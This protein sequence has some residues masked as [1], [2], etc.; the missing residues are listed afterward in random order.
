MNEKTFAFYIGGIKP[1]N[2]DDVSGVIRDVRIITE[3]SALGHNV[4]IDSTTIDQIFAAC[5]QYANGVKVKMNH[6]GGAG[7][8]PGYVTN[9]RKMSD[10]T[11]EYLLGDLHLFAAH[12]QRAYILEMA[13]RIPD[14]FGLSL[15][16]I[17]KPE[18]IEG[19]MKARC[20]RV[21]S[22]DIVTEPAANPSLF[23]VGPIVRGTETSQVDKIKKSMTPEEF[24]QC[25][26]TYEAGKAGGA[27]GAKVVPTKETHEVKEDGS[28]KHVITKGPTAPAAEDGEGEKDEESEMASR[29]A[30]KVMSQLAAQGIRLKANVVSDSAP[31]TETQKEDA[32]PMTFERLVNHLVTVGDETGKKFSRS[33]AIAFAAKRHSDLHENYLE[34]SAMDF[35]LHRKLI[36]AN[37]AGKEIAVKFNAEHW[38]VQGTAKPQGN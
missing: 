27:E 17:G 36:D 11:G 24:E 6:D 26:K 1:G 7:D 32:K 37:R 14:T 3:G 34:R 38:L 35:T 4:D 2:I 31:K 8:I 25:M 21:F 15:F 18:E 9:F 30:G 29:I 33:D 23:S 10:S 22:C 20:N 28:E 12:P 16:F 19:R 5:N 13:S